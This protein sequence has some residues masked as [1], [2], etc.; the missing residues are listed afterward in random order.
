MICITFWGFPMPPS[1]NHAYRNLAIRGRPG[2]VKTKEYRDFEREVLFWGIGHV[3][4]VRDAQDQL[5]GRA[6][7][8]LCVERTFFF[9]K[10]EIYCKDGT[11]KQNDTTN[12]IKLLDDALAK[13]LGVD[14]K[15]FWS[16]H[17]S[18]EVSA[19]GVR[20]VKISISE[21]M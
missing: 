20:S 1:V 21:L 9:P 16:G 5:A 11:V 3:N 6:Q 8:R 17:I 7:P 10:S 2:R 14:D 15:F 13:L 19:G 12:R 18:K 4:E